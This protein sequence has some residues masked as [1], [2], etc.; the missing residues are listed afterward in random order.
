LE[1]E[2]GVDNHLKRRPS[3]GLR[4]YPDFGRYILDNQFKA[5]KA[6]MHF[7]WCTKHILLLILT[8]FSDPHQKLLKVILLMLDESMSGWMPTS[9]NTGG[10]STITYEPLKSVYLGMMFRNGAE[11][12]S[13]IFV[14]QDLVQDGEVMKGKSQ[15][16]EKSSMPNGAE[17]PTHSAE[18]L[19]QIEGARVVDG[20]WVGGDAWFGCMITALDVMKRLNLESTW[21]IKG[22]H[23]LYPICALHAV[24]KACFGYKTYGNWIVMTTHI[25]GFPMLALAYVWSQKGVS[26]FL[27]RCGNTKVSSIPYRSAFEDDFGNVDYKILPGQQRAHSI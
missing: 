20:C 2:N 12:T 4:D 13:D 17:I 25:D 26:Y 22:T 16:R 23:S 21:I 18:V 24:L 5:F 9:T 27:S 3:N 15:F 10:M 6:S 1:I 11:C 8:K 7:L 19:H 14:F